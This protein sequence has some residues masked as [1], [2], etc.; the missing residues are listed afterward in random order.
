[1]PLHL[2]KLCV[3]AES[4]DDLERWI[5]LRLAEKRRA[6]QAPEQL[7]HDPDGSRSGVAELL[8]GGS[9][10]WVVKGQIAV[11]QALLDVRPFTDGEGIG[12]CHLVL[13]PDLVEV[14][15]RP[16]RPFQGWRYLPVTSAPL[17]LGA[18][19]P[20]LKALPELLRRELRDLGLI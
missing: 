13:Q 8:A 5:A 4:I 20:E 2:L 9:L 12:R 3:G 17:D 19:R 11:R 10:F 18:E 6:G 7:P 16:C 15:P 14:H 1:M